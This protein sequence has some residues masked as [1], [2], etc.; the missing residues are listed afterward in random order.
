MKTTTKVMAALC[1]VAF[2]FGCG[3]KDKGG[4]GGSGKKEK[5]SEAK[6][7]ELIKM[8]V[9]GFETQ[10][11]ARVTKIIGAMGAMYLKGTKPN[12]KGFVPYA[13]VVIHGCIRCR[14]MDVAVWKK[15]KKQTKEYLM[16]TGATKKNP[17][18]VFEI[19]ELNL[20][21]RKCIGIYTRAFNKQGRSTSSSHGLGVYCN[22][23]VNS[24][25][26]SVYSRYSKGYKST[27]SEEE[28][29]T[30]FTK[31]EM[32]TAAKQIIEVFAA[33]IF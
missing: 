16:M 19:S 25:N 10:P 9:P 23:G 8:K 28:L 21:G 18:A 29:K 24:I 32:E 3:K 30:N 5:L 20:A 17:N 14:K 31:A 12:A 11:G 7:N 4:K 22:D 1:C 27:N 33:K 26:V 2:M 6:L 13:H 15:E